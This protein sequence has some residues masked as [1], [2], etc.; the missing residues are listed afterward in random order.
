M[1]IGLTIIIVMAASSFIGYVIGY[2]QGKNNL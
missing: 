1:S 2:Y